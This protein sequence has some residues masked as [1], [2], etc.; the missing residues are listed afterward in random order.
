[1][2]L[3][4]IPEDFYVEEINEFD[5]LPHGNYKLYYVEKKGIET[6]NLLKCIS[7]ENRIPVSDFGIA[8]LKDKY[9]DTKQY[10]T[11]PSKYEI[12]QQDDPKN[13]EKRNFNATF[14]GHVNKAIRVGDLIGNKFRVVVRDIVKGEIEGVM[15]KAQSISTI[16]MPNYFDSQRFG[17]LTGSEFIGK[18]VIKKDYE[19]AVKI[20]LT[21][22]TKFE[23]SQVK[24]EKKLMLKNWGRW[25]DFSSIRINTRSLFVVKKEYD[26]TGSWIRA[27]QKVSPNL[28]EMHIAAY[29]SY[30]WN[31]CIKELLRQT[32]DLG[33]LYGKR[34]PS[35]LRHSPQ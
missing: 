26:E 33:N 34:N 8:G 3:R 4:Q 7:Q 11:I 14:M 6:F 25:D 9:A 23:K 27:Y 16:G 20:F 15:Q 2:K 10:I 22:Q 13:Q 35:C 29:Q 21:E 24:L 19:Q 18:C 12:K 5:I 28:R 1:M 32:V 31:E 30:L 17:S